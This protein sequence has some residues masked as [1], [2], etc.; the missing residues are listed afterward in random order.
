MRVCVCVCA[1]TRVRVCV[2]S[3]A[4]ERACV[5]AR[6]RSGRSRA[7]PRPRAPAQRWN[8]AAKF[9]VDKEGNVVERSGDNDAALIEKLVS[10]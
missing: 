2:R 9:Y 5:R 1:C 7:H 8:F 6:V 10:A 3:C 4:C